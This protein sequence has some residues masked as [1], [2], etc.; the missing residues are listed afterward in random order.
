MSSYTSLSIQSI[1]KLIADGE[2]ETINY[3][4]SN[5]NMFKNCNARNVAG[6]FVDCIKQKYEVPV[7]QAGKPPQATNYEQRQ[8]DDD[9][10][11]S[12]YDNFKDD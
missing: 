12:L 10:W 3:Y 9:H 7:K 5:W 8:Y 11:E 6:F 2:E 4:L 1:K